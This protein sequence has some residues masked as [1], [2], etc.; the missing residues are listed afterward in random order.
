M[1]KLFGKIKKPFAQ[2]GAGENNKTTT[3]QYKNLDLTVSVLEY[4]KVYVELGLSIIPLKPRDK[5]PVIKEWKPYQNNKT[6]NEDLEKWFKDTNN[7]IGIV[8]GVVSGNLIVIDF[9]GEEIYQ[10]FALKILD[11]ELSAKFDNTWVVKTKKGYHVY[12]RIDTDPETFR[13]VFRNKVKLVERVNQNGVTEQVDV[14]GEGGYVVAPPSIHPESTDDNIIH[15]EFIKG[16]S[17]VHEPAKITIDEW[18]ELMKL[19]GANPTK[20]LVDA[21]NLERQK[22]ESQKDNTSTQTKAHSAVVANKR[23]TDQQR[24]GEECRMLSDKIIETIENKLLQYYKKGVR[25]EIIKDMLGAFLKANICYESAWKF[26][27]KITDDGNDEEKKDRLYDVDYHYGKRAISPG[28]DKLKG[29]GGIKEVIENE[30]IRRNYSQD[31]ATQEASKVVAEIYSMLGLRKAPGVA[32]LKGIVNNQITE[33]IAQGKTGIYAYRTKGDQVEYI[34]VAPIRIKKAVELKVIG[35]K[36][37]NLYKVVLDDGVELW[38]TL[39]EIMSSL[40]EQYPINPNYA[41]ALQRLIDFMADETEEVYYSPGVWVVDGKIKFVN[42]PGYLPL[43]KRDVRWEINNENPGDKAVREALL[44]IK[45]LVEAYRDPSKASTVLSY[46]VI[47]P[48]APYVKQ[49]LNI[50]P[51]LL[52]HGLEGTGKSVLLDFVKL[53]LGINWTDELPTSEYQASRLFTTATLPAVVDEISSLLEGYRKDLVN[54]VKAVEVI[55]RSATQDVLRVMGGGEYGGHYLAIR[56]MIAT[57]NGDIT[58]VTWQLD[59]FII[60]RISAE[61]ALDMNKAKGATPRTMDTQTKKAVQYVG[62]LLLNRLETK[63]SEIERL[64]MMQREVLKEKLIDIGYSLWVELYQEYGLDPFPVPSKGESEIAKATLGDMINDIFKSLVEKARESCRNGR[65]SDDGLCVE[66]VN[67]DT[68]DIDDDPHVLKSLETNHALVIIENENG[69]DN[70]WI[71]MKTA[72]LN[73]VRE[74]MVNKYG[75]PK[76]GWERVAEYIHAKKTRRKIGGETLNNLYV[77]E[78]S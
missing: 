73:R 74:I 65:P 41:Y 52:I 70:E 29:L 37:N 6:T 19:L 67:A 3:D 24:Q 14:R 5:K 27:D 66:E 51:H 61:E 7:N 17:I 33:W 8:C 62:Y 78:L 36:T 50:F 55:H 38:G 4:A 28:I 23:I 68:T 11:S 56:S 20:D 77:K 12:F 35:L 10:E 9:D 69:N 2:K 54:S 60:L 18:N 34:L 64:K 45:Q 13:K 48:I 15:Y 63:L 72:F 53:L 16:P 22:G 32:W 21:L 31:E 30:L 57:T 42:E 26:V 46:A 44:R 76:L 49:T 58:L 25:H 40:K 43:W 71:I 75:L 39:S 1:S 59:K 47:A